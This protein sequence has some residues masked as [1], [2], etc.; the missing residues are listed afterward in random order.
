[1]STIIKSYPV[2]QFQT[3]LDVDSDTFDL[4]EMQIIVPEIAMI[5]DTL[6]RESVAP[7]VEIAFS[8]DNKEI[9]IISKES[10]G[11]TNIKKFNAIE[12]LDKTVPDFV[13]G[14]YMAFQEVPFVK[15]IIDEIVARSKQKLISKNLLPVPFESKDAVC[16]VTKGSECI[17]I[18]SGLSISTNSIMTLRNAHKNTYK[19]SEMSD[20]EIKIFIPASDANGIIRVLSIEPDS[21]K[22]ET[23]KVEYSELATYDLWFTDFLLDKYTGKKDFFGKTLAEW[24]DESH[25]RKPWKFLE[26]VKNVVCSGVNKIKTRKFEDEFLI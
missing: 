5:G 1:M 16:F 19:F 21:I 25:E 22:Y 26:N 23:N 17:E 6:T 15:K 2:R 8:D 14:S 3:Q 10:D 7:S 9:N 18:M 11:S 13:S 4:P 20:A 12:F 24:F